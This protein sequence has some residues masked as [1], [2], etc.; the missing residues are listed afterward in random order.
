M[1]TIFDDTHHTEGS[2]DDHEREDGEREQR[3][4]YLKQAFLGF[5]KAKQGVEMQHLGRVICAI[6]GLS[7]EEQYTIMEGILKLT[8]AVQVTSTF[9]S[10]AGSFSSIFS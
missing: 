2:G 10:M 4:T 7:E 6:L 5:F 8:P 9:E 3:L 1:V